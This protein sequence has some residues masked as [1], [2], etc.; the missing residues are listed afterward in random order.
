MLRVHGTELFYTDMI[1]HQAF[2]PSKVS[3]K[4][5][6]TSSQ[7]LKPTVAMAQLAACCC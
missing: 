4:T 1:D 2:R 7:T 3:L 5:F 6:L